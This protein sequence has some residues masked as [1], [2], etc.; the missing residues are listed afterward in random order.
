MYPLTLRFS[1]RQAN[2]QLAHSCYEADRGTMVMTGM[3]K[4]FRGYRHFIKEQQRHKEAFGV[5]PIRAVLIEA[6]EGQRAVNVMQLA[7]RPLVS[8]SGKRAGLFWFC[9]SPLFIDAAE[10]SSLPRHLDEPEAV[11]DP[12]WALPDRTLH[13]WPAKKIFRFTPGKRPP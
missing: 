4:K 9:I 13:P 8:G 5:H 7:Q 2:R 1:R 12:I 6:T 3:L 10:N 11:L